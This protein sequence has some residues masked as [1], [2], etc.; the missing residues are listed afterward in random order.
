MPAIHADLYQPESALERLRK[1]TLVSKLLPCLTARGVS[2]STLKHAHHGFDL[3]QPGKDSFVHRAA[4]ASEVFVAS[5]KRWAI[6][7][8]LRGEPEW[9]L[10]ALVAK[11]SPVDL[12]VVE[13]FKRDALPKLVIYRAESGKSLIHPED[14]RIFAVASDTALPLAGVPVIALEDIDGIA[15]LVLARA[16]LVEQVIE[17]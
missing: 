2:V 3:D 13:G 5:A 1:T 9:S 10:G 11:M 6:L 12:V 17:R 4:G 14:P 7:H 8:E 15:E 16:V